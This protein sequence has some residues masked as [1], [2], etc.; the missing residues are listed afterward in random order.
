MRRL[1]IC[2][3]LALALLPQVMA[4]AAAPQVVD[5]LVHT[6]TG[7]GEPEL[8]LDVRRPRDVVVGENNTGVSVSHDAGRTWKQVSM[9]NQGDNATTVDAA[10]T[11]VYTS[12]DGDVQVSKDHGDHWAS[13]GNWVGAL[14]ALWKDLAPDQLEG[15]VPFRDLGCNAP[16]GLGPVDPVN[17]PGFHVIGCDRPWIT[18]DATVPGHLYVFFTDHS[19][20]SGGTLGPDLTCKSST[21]TNQFFSCG[22]Q[23]VTSSVDGG[24]TWKPFVPVDSASTP[25]DYTNGFA[26]VPVARAGVLASAYLAGKSPGSSCTTC[27]VFQTS[28]DAGTT[29]T[30][31]VVPASVDGPALGAHAINPLDV[32]SSLAFEPYL[33]QDPSRAGRYAL[34]VFDRTQTHLLVYVTS[35][36]GR[37]WAGPATLGEAGG[38]KRHLPWIAYGAGGALGAMWKTTKADGSFSVWA[39]VS[40][41]GTP[42]FA[43]PVRLSSKD[44]P[45]P[46]N[47][48]AGDDASTVA[49]D[50]TT[51]HAAWGDRREGSLGIHYARYAFAQDRAV[52]TTPPYA[53][54]GTTPKPTKH[55]AGLA[56]TGGPTGLAVLGLALLVLVAARRRMAR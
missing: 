54:P 55:G 42:R 33:A 36:A 17:G 53:P 30:R 3:V 4:D 48:V 38:V 40:P 37:T 44:S 12:L 22:R 16:I 34:M 47:Q 1:G 26:N 29:W 31:H 43:R 41:T 35:D 6:D 50:R 14:S 27:L 21:A 2:L 49:L 23:Y 15:G 52:T 19:D 25:A 24:R 45:G 13:V 7:V 18:A 39:A 51:L 8:A 9:P 46:V 56:A 28:S 11:Y 10:G 32:N 5:T 20:G